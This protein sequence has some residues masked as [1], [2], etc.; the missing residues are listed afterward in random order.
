MLSRQNIP[1]S[2][3][4]NELKKEKISKKLQKEKRPTKKM[5]QKKKKKEKQ[6]LLYE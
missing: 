1:Y 4:D 5:S 3:Y 6:Y 2:N